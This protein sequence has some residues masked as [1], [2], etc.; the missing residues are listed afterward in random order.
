VFLFPAAA[1]RRGTPLAQAFVASMTLGAGQFCTNPG[2]LIG[3]GGA[4]LDA[5]IA[6][7]TSA[8]GNVAA[9][10]MLSASIA[11]N[12]A[13][14]V[15]QL[16]A[17]DGVE[18][19]ARGR[20]EPGPNR[21]RATLSIVEGQRFIDEPRMAHEVF[22]A[23]SLVVRVSSVEDFARIARSLEGQLTA[24]LLHDPEDASA[25][26]TLLPALERRV[27]RIVS[28]GWPTGVEVARSMVHSGPYPATSD[29]RSSSVGSLAIQRFLRP[30]C[31]QDLSDALLPAA[32]QDAN[33]WQLPRRVDGTLERS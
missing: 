13:N 32:L 7:A 21:C 27:G 30:V 26:A 20:D 31:Y 18:V 11:S 10:P 5:F 22:G 24:T 2:L 8:L 14:G 1:R 9:P 23:S 15:R 4:D 28:N 6:S 29:G 3:V 19:V 25:V 33:P 16:H 12:Y 17:L